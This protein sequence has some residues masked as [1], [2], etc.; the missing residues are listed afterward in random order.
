[1][2]IRKR[3]AVYLPTIIVLMMVLLSCSPA[4]YTPEPPIVP[5]PPPGYAPFIFDIEVESRAART[6]LDDPRPNI[7]VILTD[8]QP[9]HTVA[10]MPTVTNELAPKGVNFTNGFVTTPLCCPSRVS[11]LTGEY[12]H[13]HEVFTNSMPTGGAE[14]FDDSSSIATWMKEAGYR[15]AYFGKYLNG[16]ERLQPTGVVP[17]GWDEWRVFLGQ[18]ADDDA[19]AGSFEYFYNFTM[20]ENGQVTDYP[21]DAYYFSAD[22]VTRGAV[23]YI[24]ETRDAPFLLLI[25]YY[26]PH[27]PYIPA[28]RHEGAFRSGAGWDWIQYRPPN[29]N[30]KDIHDK[31]AYLRDFPPLSD[32]EVDTAHKQIL[33][34]LLSVDDGV[35]SVLNALDKTGL[36]E[37]TVVVFL[38]DNG[39]TLGDHRFGVDKNCAYEAC[40]KIPFIVYA[41]GMVEARSDDRLVAN[42]DLVP[43]FLEWAGGEIP[44]SVDGRSLV[45]LLVDANAPWREDL[46]LEHWRTEGGV[47][48]MI[49]EFH[50]VRTEEWKYV[51]YETGEKELY[52]LVNDPYELN[53][54]AGK[55]AYREI[56]ARLAERLAELK[57]E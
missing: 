15:T 57:Q 40:V 6:R 53:N 33:R 37:K 39:M 20:S 21:R 22:V 32:G 38:S 2:T 43:T 44:E 16:Y 49:P 56:E 4:A 36:K 25:G 45:P 35:A 26:N 41:P 31:P 10:Y 14:K 42:I 11:I 48:S 55:R 52:D 51:E 7:I 17:P 5:Q 8:D 54:L 46:L 23:N 19:D 3:N 50:A 34:S 13:N 9:Y 30:E 47:G 12:V 29:F 24:H 1:M 28:P 18:G 27:S